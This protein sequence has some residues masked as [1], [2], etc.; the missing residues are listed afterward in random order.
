MRKMRSLM[1]RVR[2][3][4]TSQDLVVPE[5]R[6]DWVSLPRGP[7]VPEE[8]VRSTFRLL[9]TVQYVVIHVA[10]RWT[11]VI[12]GYCLAS[13]INVIAVGRA[14]GHFHGIYGELTDGQWESTALSLASAHA[15]D[16]L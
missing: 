14:R 8:Q 3:A 13:S 2:I 6:H 12:V 4:V 10:S 11:G 1:A 9:G 15:I 16:E 5:A 7:E